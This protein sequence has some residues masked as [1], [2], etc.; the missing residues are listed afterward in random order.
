MSSCNID[1]PIAD[2]EQKLADQKSFLPANLHDG[3]AKLLSERPDQE[4]LNEL[5]HLLKKYDLASE[6]ERADRDKK[7]SQLLG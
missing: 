4:T 1:H 2:V 7:L 6:E 5:F 3:S